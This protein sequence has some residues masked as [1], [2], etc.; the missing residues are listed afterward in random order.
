MMLLATTLNA[1][2]PQPVSSIA[3]WPRRLQPQCSADRVRRFAPVLGRGD[4][5]PEDL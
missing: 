3:L 5:D 4:F 1:E 2:L